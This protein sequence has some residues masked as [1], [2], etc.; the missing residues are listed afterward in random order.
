[1][2][3]LVKAITGWEVSL[4]ELMKVGERRLNMMRVFNARE[5]F[6]RQDDKLP[7]KFFV[8]LVGTGPSAGV[9]IDHS[10]FETALDTYYQIMGWTQ[11]GLPTKTKMV[12][13]G[14]EWAGEYLPA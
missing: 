6:N 8:P 12:D 5:G 14:I 13:L 11:Q 2:V 1:M 7:K 10:E 3:Q 9:A 4:F